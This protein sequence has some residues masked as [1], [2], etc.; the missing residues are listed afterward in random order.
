MFESDR[1]YLSLYH[2][3]TGP[4]CICYKYAKVFFEIPYSCTLKFKT[5][6]GLIKYI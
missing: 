1:N 6:K 4:T 3:A 5:L 2:L